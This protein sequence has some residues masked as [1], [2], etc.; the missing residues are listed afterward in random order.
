MTVKSI[1]RM[2]LTMLY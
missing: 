1:Q 2:A